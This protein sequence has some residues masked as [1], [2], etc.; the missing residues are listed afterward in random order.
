MNINVRNKGF[1]SLFVLAVVSLIV[2]S[3]TATGVV[4]YKKGISKSTVSISESITKE[5][6]LVEN[7][8]IIEAGERGSKAN[9]EELDKIKQEAEKIGTEEERLKTEQ[10][11]KKLKAEAERITEQKKEEER[12]AEQKRVE[13]QKSKE[14]QE[15][16]L[17]EQGKQRLEEIEKEHQ[18]KIAE[19]FSQ[20]Q[21]ITTQQLQQTIEEQAQTIQDIQKD[22]QKIV[23]N[24][25]PIPSVDFIWPELP[26]FQFIPRIHIVDNL[27]LLTYITEDYDNCSAKLLDKDGN[28]ITTSKTDSSQGQYSP[29]YKKMSLSLPIAVD[30]SYDYSVTCS[31]GGYKDNTITNSIDIVPSEITVTRGRGK[32]SNDGVIEVSK[33]LPYLLGDFTIHLTGS[34]SFDI[35]KIKLKLNDISSDIE[36][37]TIKSSHPY[38]SVTL[39]KDDISENNNINFVLNNGVSTDN[40]SGGQG[41]SILGE[42]SDSAIGKTTNIEL[43]VEGTTVTGRKL[44]SNFALGQDLTFIAQE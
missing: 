25:T 40:G 16:L 31:K 44:I 20:K 7:T 22:I 28:I 27:Q 17:L 2:A 4:L 19:A 29:S 41:I 38:T 37:L 1:I 12:L 8:E 43:S 6:E 42:L 39:R 30:I 34:E 15:K 35:T 24:T 26:I 32:W 33:S 21:Q 13:E 5:S 11:I 10:E 23:E 18:Q 36:K 9:S 14:E 3:A